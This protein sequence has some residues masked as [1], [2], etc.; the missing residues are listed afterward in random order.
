MCREA[1]YLA[2]ICIQ[3][4]GNSASDLIGDKKKANSITETGN[5]RLGVAG[6][7][8]GAAENSV[9]LSSASHVSAAPPHSTVR[10]FFG[11]DRVH[12][13]KKKQKRIMA[14]AV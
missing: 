13:V 6:H 14:F 11:G 2:A 3:M 12:G 8:S 10:C 4:A 1:V 9:D 7:Q 5:Y